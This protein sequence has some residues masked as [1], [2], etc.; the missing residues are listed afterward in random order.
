MALVSSALIAR[1][2]AKEASKISKKSLGF[3]F[4][5]LLTSLVLYYVIAFAFAK[6]MEASKFASLPCVFSLINVSWYW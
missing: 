3:D 2:G 5:P 1:Q 6:F 4:I